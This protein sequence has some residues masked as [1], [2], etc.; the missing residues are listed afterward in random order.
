[1]KTINEILN[2]SKEKD[3]KVKDYFV[4]PNLLGYSV[5]GQLISNKESFNFTE[6]GKSQMCFKLGIPYAYMEKCPEELQSVN[7]NHFLEKSKA[8]WMLRTVEQNG[9]QSV[10]SV[11]TDKYSIFDNTEILEMVETAVDGQNHEIKHFHQDEGFDGFHM[12]ITFPETS[13]DAGKLKN[14]KPDILTFGLHVANSE[15]GKRSVSIT[16]LIYRLVCTNGLM[17][18]ADKGERFYQRHVGIHREDMPLRVAEAFT[19]AIAQGN[20]QM[21]RFAATK[22]QTVADPLKSIDE[23]ARRMKNIYLPK[24]FAETTKLFLVSERISDKKA[25]VYDLVN[26]FTRAAQT[27]N[28]DQ[29]VAVETFIYKELI[30]A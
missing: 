8:N 9:V 27:L 18:V 11:L 4:D 5:N 14:G 17:V 7:I 16:P 30:A 3:S 13:F 24:N 25:T 23:I 15:V 2:A 26:S 28:E 19:K 12:R 20:D 10:R 22:G 21:Q 6:W 1:M 29:R